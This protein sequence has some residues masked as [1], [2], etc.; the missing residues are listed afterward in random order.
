MNEKF[1]NQYKNKKIANALEILKN[2]VNE[3]N[4]K[5]AANFHFKNKTSNNFQNY[6]SKILLN[7][8]YYFS[9]GNFFGEFKSKYSLQGIDNNCLNNFETRKTEIIELIEM[10]DLVTLYFSHFAD[11]K[12]KSKKKEVR[13]DLD[14]FYTKFVHTFLPEKY[15]PLDNPI[16][17]MLGFKK[18]SF[19]FSFFCI[20][21]LYSSFAKENASLVKRIKEI[22]K[23]SETQKFSDMNLID[24]V[25][26][27]E[28]DTLKKKEEKINKYKQHSKIILKE[29]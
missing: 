26:W 29:K 12:I 21:E 2:K 10:N 7:Q 9:N 14:S 13:K 25:L 28:A 1:I 19:I 18:E 27:K 6:Y 24:L 20:A 16:K 22:F 17:N 11:R 23:N 5:E 8:I 4:I 3:K 15:P